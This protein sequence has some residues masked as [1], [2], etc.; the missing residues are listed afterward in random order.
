MSCDK[1][2][3]D[4]AMESDSSPSVFV[5]KDWLN[6]LDNQ[7]GNY[8]SNSS[9]IETSS[10]SN[11]SSSIISL[12]I[13]S[14]AI[15]SIITIIS[16]IS[17]I[18]V[19]YPKTSIIINK[20]TVPVRWP[21]YITKGLYRVRDTEELCEAADAGNGSH[22]ELN[23]RSPGSWDSGSGKIRYEKSL[24]QKPKKKTLP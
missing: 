19:V 18:N 21:E 12:S 4:L 17:Y 5:R 22:S 10:L 3:F 13:I 24:A 11:S 8:N 1:L 23:S 15:L 9:V 2:V 20:S 7:N 16:I 6:I 14:L